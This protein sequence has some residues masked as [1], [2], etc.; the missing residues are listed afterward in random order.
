M[1][2]AAKCTVLQMQN[3]RIK[4]RKGLGKVGLRRF[5]KTSS[6]AAEMTSHGRLFQRHPPGTGNTRSPTVESSGVYIVG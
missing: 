3:I 6:A 2:K 4:G 1:L 5:W